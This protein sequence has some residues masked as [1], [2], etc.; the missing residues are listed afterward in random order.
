MYAHAGEINYGTISR[1]GKMNT[2]TQLAR[3]EGGV[4][5]RALLFLV[6]LSSGA[7]A[8]TPSLKDFLVEL[9]NGVPADLTTVFAYSRHDLPGLR[10]PAA[11]YQVSHSAL[12]PGNPSYTLQTFTFSAFDAFDPARGDGGSAYLLRRARSYGCRDARRRQP[13]EPILRAGWV[14]GRRL[15]I[16]Y[17][18][19]RAAWLVVLDKGK[20]RRCVPEPTGNC[21][22]PATA[23]TQWR[24][25]LASMYFLLSGVPTWQPVWTIIS[26]HY[27]GPSIAESTSMERFYFAYGYG[28]IRWEAWTTNT[29]TP[30]DT[31]LLGRCPGVYIDGGPWPVAEPAPHWRQIACRSWT[32]IIYDGDGKKTIGG[33]RWSP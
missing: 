28:W 26:E 12:W 6:A 9:Q 33:I 3:R 19:L 22:S 10:G 4:L 20:A 29:A 5:W 31:D 1:T 16:L 23:F 8:D 7:A 11:G 32:N 17:A 14:W 18:G 27:A 21:P 30:Q 24:I 15:D 2:T 13:G 25:E